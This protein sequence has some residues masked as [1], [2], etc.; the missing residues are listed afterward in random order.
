M[1]NT[2]LAKKPQ[3]KMA[4]DGHAGETSLFWVIFGTI[5]LKLSNSSSVGLNHS[6]IVMGLDQKVTKL[7]EHLKF[8]PVIYCYMLQTCSR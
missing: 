4:H 8:N 7:L 3:F 2:S 6:K 5:E 1:S